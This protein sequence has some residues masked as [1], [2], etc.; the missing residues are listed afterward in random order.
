[1]TTQQVMHSTNGTYDPS[2]TLSTS[3]QV[4]DGSTFASKTAN[5]SAMYDWGAL[6][7]MAGPLSAR[8]QTSF[9]D[10]R[11]VP[12]GKRR[13]YADGLP[14]DWAIDSI[15]LRGRSGLSLQT[16]FTEFVTPGTHI[17]NDAVGAAQFGLALRVAP[18]VRPVQA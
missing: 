5:A 7:L 9:R 13:R 17:I 11:L 12:L 3:L 6:G 14:S 8:Y 2:K 16:G 15:T 1:M 4:R 18:A 10:A